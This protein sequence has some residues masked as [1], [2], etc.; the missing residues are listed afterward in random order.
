M[1]SKEPREDKVVKSPQS[2]P[3]RSQKSNQENGGYRSTEA[4]SQ[5]ERAHQS[6]CQSISSEQPLC[7][8][9]TEH[10]VMKKAELPSQCLPQ[11]RQKI[12]RSHRC[13]P[14]HV[15][16][17]ELLTQVMGLTLQKSRHNPGPF[18]SM[19]FQPNLSPYTLL[20]FNGRQNGL[21]QKIVS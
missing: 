9:N 12:S 15:L 20:Y 16:D 8:R 18:L 6:F 1:H 21:L 19:A 13:S 3:L 5:K 4:V 14:V 2:L 10:R 7:V 17:I 11:S